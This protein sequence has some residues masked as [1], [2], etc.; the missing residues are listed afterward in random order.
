MSEQKTQKK[1]IDWLNSKGFY[2]VKTITCNRKGVPDILACAPGGQFIAIEVKYGTN[3]TSK[4]QEYN[5]DVINK[6]GGLAFV[7]YDLSTV[8]A[9]VQ[10]LI[11]GE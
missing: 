8:I 10:H 1:I 11:K 2:V 6:T 9:N 3:K 7:A 4:L 5:I